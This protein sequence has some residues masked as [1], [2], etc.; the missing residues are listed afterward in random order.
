[1]TRSEVET[2]LGE[3]LARGGGDDAATSYAYRSGYLSSLLATLCVQVPEAAA[4]LERQ[5]EF[6][7]RGKQ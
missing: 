1:M 7:T 2:K 6:V 3:L 5:H 4:W